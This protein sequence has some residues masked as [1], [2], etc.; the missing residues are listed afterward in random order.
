MRYKLD[1]ARL[2]L[3]TVTPETPAREIEQMISQLALTC[4]VDEIGGLISE[5]L[6]A[7]QQAR[8]ELA[9]SQARLSVLT[10]ARVRKRQ[11]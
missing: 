5:A 10:K 8:K 1:A 4:S 11:G 3:S 9:Y 7:E 2:K 6:D